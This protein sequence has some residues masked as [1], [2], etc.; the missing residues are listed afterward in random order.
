MPVLNGSQLRILLGTVCAFALIV[1]C[2]FVSRLSGI[3]DSTW[4]EHSENNWLQI[5]PSIVEV[6]GREGEKQTIKVR[7]KNVGSGVHTLVAANTSCGCTVPS[8]GES[9][10]IYPNQAVEANLV[11]NPPRYGRKDSVVEFVDEDGLSFRVS[12][13]ATGSVR[14]PPLLVEAPHSVV[15]SFSQES[16]FA[17]FGFRIV[18]IERPESVWLSK[19]TLQCGEGAVLTAIQHSDTEGNDGNVTR[20]YFLEVSCDTTMKGLGDF[21]T[22]I[23]IPAGTDGHS[24]VIRLNAQ[25]RIGVRFAPE[26]VVFSG[27]S[28]SE[29]RVLVTFDGESD[30]GCSVASDSD[31][32]RIVSFEKLAVGRWLLV[33]QN[34]NHEA[35]RSGRVVLKN[36]QGISL[37][38]LDL[39]IR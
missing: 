39:L 35:N 36:S 16:P 4:A 9:A 38:S 6:A 5:E 26:I 17:E 29:R 32:F 21:S 15:A 37:G 27:R 2:L 12:V 11:I 10:R 20:E 7:L 14:M 8:L 28:F 13:I 18:T 3:A 30:E 34:T 19:S 23:L 25:Q 1:P 24:R 33:V 22:E 31:S